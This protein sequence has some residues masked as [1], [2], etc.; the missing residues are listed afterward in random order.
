[1]FIVFQNPTENIMI[2]KHFQKKVKKIYLKKNL[3]K[4]F[5]NIMFE[6]E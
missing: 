1:M 4:G 6:M 2:K 3:I 5:E